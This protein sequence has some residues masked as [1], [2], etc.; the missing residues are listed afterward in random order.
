MY[1][2]VFGPVPSRRLGRSLGVN[3]IPYKHCTYSCVY[4]QVGRTSNLTIRRRS[5]YAPKDIVAEVKARIRE[6]G[7][8][9]I[10]YVSIVPDG[11]PTLDINLGTL[12]RILK[13][14]VHAP[15]AVFTNASLLHLEVVRADLSEADL[16]SVK[17]DAV[18]VNT[19]RAVNRPC[20][21]LRLN[22]VLNGIRDFSREFK[23]TLITETMLVKGV[24]DSRSALERI[25]SFL[26]EVNALT[27]YIMIPT[28][29]PAET[30][31]TPPSLGK[32]LMAYDI[33]KAKLG[34]GKVKYI[35]YLEGADFIFR[36]NV[37]EEILAVLRV[38][39]I[40]VEL[41][42]EFLKRL[43]LD[44]EEVIGELLRSG[45]VELRTYMGRD[46]LVRRR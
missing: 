26:S 28:R 20:L 22:D 12:I 37:K 11:E 24:N 30:W 42:R 10:D 43:N 29:P 18:D 14:E 45:A 21:G 38:H 46:Y 3:N 13:R 16:V 31:A 41:A 17:V 9:N 8:D 19:W 5:F 40:A 39:S 34:E 25:A 35:N 6:V 2:Y 23:G 7:E 36:K 33:F 32:I 27:N 1:K 44:P 4:C 15:I